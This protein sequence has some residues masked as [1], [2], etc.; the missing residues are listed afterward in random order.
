MHVPKSPSLRGRGSRDV[1]GGVWL[2][3][4]ALLPKCAPQSF[5]QALTGQ[6]RPSWK[7]STFLPAGDL[8]EKKSLRHHS[9]KPD[10]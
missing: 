6:G 4:R 8:G 5:L 2:D 7:A 3:T 1:G 9:W 10:K